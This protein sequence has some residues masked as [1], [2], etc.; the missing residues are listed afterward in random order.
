MIFKNVYKV[1]LNGYELEEGQEVKEIKDFVDSE[2]FLDIET[3]Q[4]NI[5][6][7]NEIITYHGIKVFYDFGADYYFFQEIK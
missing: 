6:F 4:E 2:V 3:C 5:K 1:I 7:Y